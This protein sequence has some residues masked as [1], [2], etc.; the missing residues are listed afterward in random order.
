[1]YTHIYRVIAK[2][3]PRSEENRKITRYGKVV[4]TPGSDSAVGVCVEDLGT[5]G[6]GAL[7]FLDYIV[8][9]RFGPKPAVPKYYRA[10]NT[11]SRFTW[12][13]IQHIGAQF[14]RAVAEAHNDK[15]RIIMRP[16]T[17]C[18]HEAGLQ[19]GRATFHGLGG[20]IRSF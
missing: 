14:P 4:A 11:R 15:L 3:K 18:G 12:L 9:A 17:P 13:A 5:W 20:S 2:T 16:S 10:S 6:H 8:D 19:R 7:E 1:M